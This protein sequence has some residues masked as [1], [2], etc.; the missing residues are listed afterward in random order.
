[1][2]SSFLPVWLSL[3][4]CAEG[5]SKWWLSVWFYSIQNKPVFYWFLLLLH[6]QDCPYFLMLFQCLLLWYV[7][8]WCVYVYGQVCCGTHGVRW[9]QPHGASSFLYFC[10]GPRHQT[11][12]GKLVWQVP[13][14]LNL[15]A[16]PSAIMVMVYLKYIKACF[17]D[18]GTE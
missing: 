4:V 5:F 7:C 6:Q 17:D 14:P 10:M 8:T 18:N 13:L 11:Q 15:L 16:S 12:S 9:G 2:V 3:A 1:M